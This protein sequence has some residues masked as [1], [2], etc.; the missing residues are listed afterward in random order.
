MAF[1]DLFSFLFQRS[2]AEER[3]ASYVI[4]EH[5][6]GRDLSEILEDRYVQNRLTPDQRARLLDRPEVIKA[7]GNDTVSRARPS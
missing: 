7:I 6:R 5:E 3:V 4:R 2:S 1:R